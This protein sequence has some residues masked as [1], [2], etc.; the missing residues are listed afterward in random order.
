MVRNGRAKPRV[1]TTAT[2]RVEVESPRVNDRGVDDAGE[3]VR[4]RSAILPPWARR[5]PKVAEVV[6]LMYLYGMSTGDF[7]PALVEFFGSPAGLSAS[8]ITR[9]AAQWRAEQR[10]FAQRR[11]SHY[12]RRGGPMLLARLTSRWPRAP[13]ERQPMNDAPG[14]SLVVASLLSSLASTRPGMLQR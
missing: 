11:P 14:W 7:A 12:W 2:G 1:I 6:P 3:R 13:G 5:S 9:L 4:F 8:V 10:T